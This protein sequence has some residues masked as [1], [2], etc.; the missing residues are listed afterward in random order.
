[1]EKPIK[2][3]CVDGSTSGNPGP[4]EYKIVD[5]ETNKVL[6]VTSIGTATNNIAEFLGLCHGIFYCIKN[7]LNID[8]Y[9]DSVTAMAWVRN[10]K[11]NT[12]FT[13]DI[14]KRVKLAEIFLNTIDKYPIKKW[15]TKK[16]GEIPADFGRKR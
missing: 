6:Y 16:W 12:T 1:M 15:N 8:I 5:I 4:S 11:A 13:G 7:G 2:G 3:I 14:S 10:K 9:S